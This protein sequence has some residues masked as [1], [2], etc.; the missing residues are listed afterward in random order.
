M[1]KLFFALFGIT[2]FLAAALAII[3]FSQAGVTNQ[4]LNN[5]K[6]FYMNS[7]AMIERT[8]EPADAQMK[9]DL[10]QIQEQ[11]SERNLRMQPYSKKEPYA[12]DNCDASVRTRQY[13][14]SHCGENVIVEQQQ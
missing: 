8:V 4:Q 14:Q 13:I 6:I 9:S 11:A 2:I 3:D 12:A 7:N 5:Q 1:R 10:M